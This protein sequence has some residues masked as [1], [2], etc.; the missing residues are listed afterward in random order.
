MSL[1][2]KLRERFFH[3]CSECGELVAEI[4]AFSNKILR[5]HIIRLIEPEGYLVEEKGYFCSE[6]C[7]KTF[8]NKETL[9][10]DGKRINL[11]DLT[12]RQFAS[13]ALV[14]L[15]ALKDH[16]KQQKKKWGVKA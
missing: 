8:A 12:S 16:F 1:I 2:E 7:A 5:Y 4:D 13:L 6:D 9:F 11:P 10:F 14:E 15:K 3:H